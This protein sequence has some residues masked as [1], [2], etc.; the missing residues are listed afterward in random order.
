MGSDMALRVDP[1]RVLQCPMPCLDRTSPK[2]AFN[3]ATDPQRKLRQSLSAFDC[4]AW[5]TFRSFFHLLRRGIVSVEQL[6]DEH[7]RASS[8]LPVRRQCSIRRVNLRCVR[9]PRPLTSKIGCASMSFEPKYLVILVHGISTRALWMSEVKSGLSRR[10][11][12][13]SMTLPELSSMATHLKAAGSDRR[14]CQTGRR[15]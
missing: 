1:E 2:L 9:S 15:T 14:R 5:C 13:E 3:D 11:P 12:K 4:D 8:P 10:A 7:F 6:P